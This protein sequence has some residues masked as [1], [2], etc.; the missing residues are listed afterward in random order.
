METHSGT[1]DSYLQDIITET[2]ASEAR[3]Q[4]MC[5]VRAVDDAWRVTPS[6]GM[7]RGAG[8][9]AGRE[10]H[11]GRAGGAS[12]VAGDNCGGAGECLLGVPCAARSNPCLRSKASSCPTST[13]ARYKYA[14]PKPLLFMFFIP[15]LCLQARVM[16]DQK[17]FVSVPA[18]T[19]IPLA[20]QAAAAVSAEVE[21]SGGQKKE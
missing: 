21:A 4:V 11:R 7:E 19:V 16:E 2:V 8:Q 20:Q 13:V 5:W 17:K 14:Q 3:E 18:T 9:G 1:V 15:P 12:V 6:S 10:Q